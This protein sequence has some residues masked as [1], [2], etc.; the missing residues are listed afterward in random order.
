MPRIRLLFQW[1]AN[2]IV[3]TSHGANKAQTGPNPVPPL[4]FSRAI[5]FV[6]PGDA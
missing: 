4:T 3:N 6:I 2:G 5:A 1:P